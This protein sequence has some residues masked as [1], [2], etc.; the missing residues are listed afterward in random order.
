MVGLTQTCVTSHPEARRG[1]HQVLSRAPL[2][3]PS[4]AAIG[5]LMDRKTIVHVSGDFPDPLEPVKTRSVKNLVEA[6]DGYRHVIY[7]LNRVGGRSDIEVLPFGE[8]RLALAYGAPPYG[9]LHAT[10]LE[11]VADWILKD[12]RARGLEVDAFH[13]HKFAIE[14]LIGLKLARE[15]G[16]PFIVNIWG[17]TDLKIARVRRDLAPRWKQILTEAAGIV[18][19][20]PWATDKFEALFG[21]DRGKCEVLAPIVM[22][23]T[24]RP[25]PAAPEP[26]LVTLFNL[27]SHKRKNFGALVRAVKAISASLPQVRLDVYGSCAPPVLYELR[28]II[29]KAEAQELVTLMGPLPNE[30]FSETL[31][32]YVAFL[33]P[34]RRE[35]FGMV[36][37]EAMFAGLPVLHSKGW[38]IDGF[39]PDDT[40][41]YACVPTDEDD[42]RRGVEHLIANQARLKQSLGELHAKGGLDPFKRD[43]IVAAYRGLLGRVLDRA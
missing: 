20:A 15:T 21:I 4:V 18:P 7:S 10:R 13:V 28:E 31:N 42:V 26:R 11:A 17:D 32:R 5:Y 2:T 16:R 38:G 14:G 3:T 40:I 41:G 27:N 24:F 34:T 9:I 8:D 33:M 6:T 12:V 29:A 37:I 19:C 25:S 23:E 30:V 43:N 1:R 22:H 36:F 35:T 39:F